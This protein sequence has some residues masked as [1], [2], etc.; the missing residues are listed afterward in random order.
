[1]NTKDIVTLII[2]AILVVVILF[3]GKDV[4]KSSDRDL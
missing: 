2:L 1:M 3:V 4:S